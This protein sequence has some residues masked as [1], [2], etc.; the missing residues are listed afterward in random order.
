MKV[1]YNGKWL[2]VARVRYDYNI[3]KFCYE[4]HDKPVTDP[5]HT[6]W[7]TF[8]EKDDLVA[9]QNGIKTNKI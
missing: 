2:E 4:I 5:K 8:D 7:V 3:G 6:E 9:A 1:K